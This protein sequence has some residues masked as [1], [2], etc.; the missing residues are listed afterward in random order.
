MT[1]LLPGIRADLHG[2]RQGRLSAGVGEPKSWEPRV[3]PGVEGRFRSHPTVLR[4]ILE[5]EEAK[6]Y[7]TSAH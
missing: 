2:G 7:L 4:V 6:R 5:L 1:N 3:R